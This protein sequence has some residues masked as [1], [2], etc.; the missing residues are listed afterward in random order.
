MLGHTHC[1][2]RVVW[3]SAPLFWCGGLM[4]VC[5][6]AVEMFRLASPH[7]Q[8]HRDRR[9]ATSTCVGR[10]SSRPARPTSS[11][12]HPTRSPLLTAPTSRDKTADKTHETLA[13]PTQTRASPATGAAAPSSGSNFGPVSP[14]RK[15]LGRRWRDLCPRRV[16]LGPRPAEARPAGERAKEGLCTTES[17]HRASA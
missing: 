1:V 5:C 10:C 17:G 2:C 7:H 3:I 4:M 12:L 16:S 8:I 15:P 11:N 6:L 13:N 9:R 14:P